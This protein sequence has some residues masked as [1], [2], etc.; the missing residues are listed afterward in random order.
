MSQ[1]TRKSTT[2]TKGQSI[3]STFFSIRS[4]DSGILILCCEIEQIV[5]FF[6]LNW[7]VYNINKNLQTITPSQTYQLLHIK[8]AWKK[9]VIFVI[10]Q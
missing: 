1:M 5:L 8:Q 7:D 9:G 3:I 10:A 4:W 2:F 6:K